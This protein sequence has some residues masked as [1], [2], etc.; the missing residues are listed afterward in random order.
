MSF[1][2]RMDGYLRDRNDELAYVVAE[3]DQ[4]IA[5]RDALHT[6]INRFREA[7][8]WVA[9]A[10]PAMAE[11]VSEATLLPYDWHPRGIAPTPAP[12]GETT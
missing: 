12:E 4:A 3:R 1:N 9:T 6:Q 10:D 7:L 8:D 5:E 2:D 11:F